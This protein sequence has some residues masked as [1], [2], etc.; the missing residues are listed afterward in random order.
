MQ[1]RAWIF[2]YLTDQDVILLEEVR[3]DI[4]EK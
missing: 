3:F 1:V 4:F 2:K